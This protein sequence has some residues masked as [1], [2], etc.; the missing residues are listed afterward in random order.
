LQNLRH[1]KAAS[2]VGASKTDPSDPVTT[3][4]DMRRS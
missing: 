3:A 2:E 1:R 4:S